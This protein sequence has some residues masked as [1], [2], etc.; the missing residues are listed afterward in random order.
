MRANWTY[1][2]IL[3]TLGAAGIVKNVMSLACD[4]GCLRPAYSGILA[5][6]EYL[7]RGDSVSSKADDLGVQLALGQ[8]LPVLP[9]GANIRMAAP[10]GG[11]LPDPFRFPGANQSPLPRRGVDQ[12]KVQRTTEQLESLLKAVQREVSEASKGQLPRDLIPHL[13]RI[14]KLSKQLR[15]EISP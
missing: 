15:R 3:T 6:K 4:A 2:T 14:E 8:A 9:P 10:G 13:K 12:A 5:G 1:L 11:I 7:T